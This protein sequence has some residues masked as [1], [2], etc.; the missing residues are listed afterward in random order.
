MKLFSNGS[1]DLGEAPLWHF[2]RNSLFWLDILNR[3]LFEKNF[4]SVNTTADKSWSLPE[5]ASVMALDAH[6]ENKIWMVTDKSFGRYDLLK[7]SYQSVLNL[8]ISSS[9]RANDGGV[10]PDGSF[11]FGTMEWS[12]SGTNGSIYSISSS[13]A[14]TKHDLKIGIPNTFCWDLD[15]KT[16]FISDSWQQKMFSFDVGENAV[17]KSSAH[18]VVD[19]SNGACTPDGGAIDMDG[20]LWNAHWD[21][22]KVVKYD[23][24]GEIISELFLPVPKPTSCCFG[25]PEY[26]HLFVTSARTTMSEKD[27]NRY[28]LSGSVFIHEMDRPGPPPIA[29]YLDI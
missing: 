16:L 19:L 8:D 10:A 9:F 24:T 27:I 26:R 29:F 1:D 5:Y 14:L 15:G 18:L 20:Y 17:S 28:P 7:S 2:Q 21:G 25:G 6:D 22:H 13:A 4:E 12:P 3:K 11:W 23:R